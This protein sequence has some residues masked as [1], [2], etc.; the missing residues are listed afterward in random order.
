[1]SF[2][3]QSQ[4]NWKS[5][6]AYVRKPRLHWCSWQRPVI[7]G[8]GNA[9]SL[10]SSVPS[11]L[12]APCLGREWVTH[13][14][15]RTRL[16][17]TPPFGMK[18]MTEAQ[19]RE[20]QIAHQLLHAS[21]QQGQLL[22]R[23]QPVEVARPCPEEEESDIFQLLRPLLF[24][25]WLFSTS[26]DLNFSLKVLFKCCIFNPFSLFANILFAFPP[27][28]FPV[29]Y[30]PFLLSLCIHMFSSECLHCFSCLCDR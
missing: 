28:E 12:L 14:L 19:K 6:T 25:S 20:W 18:A 4:C 27:L 16:T 29:F 11:V 10:P 5:P 3:I 24:L 22:A 17:V 26:L 8:W 30:L 13:S 2:L 21:S 23:H 1:M 7:R 9:G 15:Y